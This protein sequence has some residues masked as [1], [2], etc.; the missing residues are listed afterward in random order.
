M[1]TELTHY[2]IL[3]MKWGVRRTPEELGHKTKEKRKKNGGQ[4]RDFESRGSKAPKKASEMT[5][6]EL[7]S[8]VN[9]LNME[10]QYRNL[11]ARKKEASIGPA[12]KALGKALDSLRDKSLEFLVNKIVSRLT[13][14][15]DEDFTLEEFEN[16]DLL[17][18]DSKTLAKIAK[19]YA[20][21]GVINKGR[22]ES[23]KKKDD[24]NSERKDPKTATKT[25]QPVQTKSKAQ[26]EKER[27]AT[28]R[29]QWKWIG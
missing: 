16:A 10:E 7:R 1:S 11:M 9:R 13:N 12:R 15:S 19:A 23:S 2:G 26:I 14:K 8:Q 21:L 18:L 24:Q 28:D 29:E 3:G 5:E 4:G 25:N 20:N 27:N 17:K 6:E 22:S